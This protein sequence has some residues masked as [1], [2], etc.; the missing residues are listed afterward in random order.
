[1]TLRPTPEI[2][3]LFGPPGVG[4]SVVGWELYCRLLSLGRRCAYVDIDQLGICYPPPPLD[5]HRHQLKADNL[6]AVVDGFARSGAQ[7]VVVTGVLDGQNGPLLDADLMQATTMIRL[8][9]EAGELVRRLAGRGGP[10]ASVDGAAREAEALDRT[11]FADAVLDTTTRSVNQVVDDIVLWCGAWAT[12]EPISLRTVD[13][14]RA[15]APGP[16]LWLWGPTAVGKSTIG[17]R[18]Y[19][20]LLDSGVPAAYA[21]VE[22]LGFCGPRP[23]DHRL[24]AR[25]LASVWDRF[26]S[27]GAKALIAVGRLDSP[28]AAGHYRDLVPELSYCGLGAGRDELRRRVLSRRFGGS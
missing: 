6:T 13:D 3:W 25:N 16:V 19:L 28:S 9:A 1:M 24:R 5:P 26:R 2:L 27:A 21:D 17:F 11:T 8:R 12:G 22:Q 4:K 10:P 7:G 20:D 15:P 18:A 23:D 14:H